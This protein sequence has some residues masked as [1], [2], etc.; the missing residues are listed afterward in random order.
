MEHS[1][2]SS[3]ELFF[4]WQRSLEIYEY[5]TTIIGA[6]WILAVPVLVLI[7]AIC[8]PLFGSSFA[9]NIVQATHVIWAVISWLVA[10]W[11]AAAI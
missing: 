10:L 3:A 6:S 1:I 4:G 11:F 2:R 7:G 5:P 9:A 8:R